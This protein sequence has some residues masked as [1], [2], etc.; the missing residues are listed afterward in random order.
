MPRDASDET[1]PKGSMTTVT[2]SATRRNVD[3][4][5]HSTRMLLLGS[6]DER[7]LAVVEAAAAQQRGRGGDEAGDDRER[8]R[9]VQPILERAGDELREE[10]G[11]RDRG[12]VGRGQRV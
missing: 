5:N 9:R 11:S 6:F 10:A 2:S 1:S 12:L 4:P 7:H 8:E 3:C